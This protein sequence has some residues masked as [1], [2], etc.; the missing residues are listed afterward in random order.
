[1]VKLLVFLALVALALAAVKEDFITEDLP[2]CGHYEFDS[3]SGYIPI[4]EKNK[5]HYVFLESQ[6]D[7]ENDPFII[8]FTGGPGCSGMLAY[9]M[10]NGPCV[11]D[12]M[13][14]DPLPHPN[15]FSWNAKA[16]LLYVD[17]PA[18]VGFN[19][20]YE[21]EY[22]DDIIAGEQEVNFTLGF[23][24]RYSEFLKNDL[25]ITGESYGGIYVPYLA[26]NLHTR[27]LTTRSG[28]HLNLQGIAVG[29]GVTDWRFDGNPAY[30]DMSLHHGLIPFD[31]A[32][33]IKESGCDF[34]ENSNSEPSQSCIRLENE[35]YS[36]VQEI[37]VYDVYR[38]PQDGG[39]MSDGSVKSLLKGEEAMSYTPF[40]RH[41]KN[42]HAFGL[43]VPKYM[44]R[45]DVRKILH[46]TD[47]KGPFE[48]CVRFN[49]KRLPQ[50]SIWAYPTLKEAGYRILK[51]TGD[52]DGAVPTLG[53]LAWIEELGWDLE[54]NHEPFIR[55][56]K[57]AGYYTK[58]DGL[59]L[60]VFHGVGHL[61]PMW[62]RET[63]QEVLYKFINGERP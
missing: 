13:D 46:V 61:V 56:G 18:G 8:W 9:F 26:Y 10:E 39:L 63:S 12:G 53:T 48:A 34:A 23:F 16:N 27:N 20:G 36:Y 52:T 5:F 11:W 1:M 47:K 14:T 38:P 25:Y 43:P 54:I 22:L 45:D 19:L 2:G 60:V 33:R 28:G 29:N 59:E 15:E 44:D 50:A 31:L 7:P 37:N 24:E 4:D 42:Q 40:L 58:R 17:N 55:D 41:T 62:M 49:Y 21:G 51:Y 30:I 6:N 35:W 32:Q 57:V 3:Y